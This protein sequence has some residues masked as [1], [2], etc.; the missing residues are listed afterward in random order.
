MT[1]AANTDLGVAARAAAAGDDAAFA[2]IVTADHE[3]MRR[4]CVVVT[5][6]EQLAE[7]AVQSAW[8]VAW[9]K[10]ETLRQPERLR[11][12]LVSVAGPTVRSG[13]CRAPGLRA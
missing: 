10:I 4:V 9:E 11:P 6:D 13:P 12:W 3:D 2:R 5:G 7:D 8:A 1:G